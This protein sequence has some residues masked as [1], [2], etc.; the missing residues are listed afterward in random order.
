M[1]NLILALLLAAPSFA[2]AGPQA[3]ARSVTIYRDTYGVPHV[4][5]KTDA[6]AVFGLMYAQAEDNFWQLETDYIGLIG[7]RAEVDGLAG[8]P[9]DLLVRAWEVEKGAKAHYEHASPQLKTVCDAFAAGLNYYLA[10]HPEVHPRLLTRFE[11]W[12]ALAEEHH[13]PAGTGITPAERAAAFPELAGTPPTAQ[14]PVNP[15]EGSNMWAV[16]PSR[17]AD[18][19]AL[20]LINPHVQFFGGGQR[21]EAHLHSDQGL[22]VSGFAMLGAPYIWSGHNR[23]LGWSHTNNY[24][25]FSDVYLESS[26]VPGDPLV[27]RYG[28]GHRFAVEWTDTVRV[29]TDT[30]FETRTVKFR[31]THHGPVLGVRKGQMLAVR[32]AAVDGG[33]MEESWIVDK[34]RNLREFQEALARR[35]YTGSNTIYADVKGNIYYL[36][37]N[38]VPKRSTK[39]DWSKPVDGS[40]PETEWQGLHTIDELPHVLNP[41]SGWVQNCNSTPF[42]TSGAADSPKASDYPAYMA[43]EADTPRSQRS[44][45][46]LDGTGRFT[47]EEWTKLGLD[48]K[49]GIAAARIAELKAALKDVAPE[50]SSKL[51]DL[52]AAL[53]QWDQVGRNDSVAATLFVRTEEARRAGV[54][55]VA[56]LEKVKAD[57]E[58]AWG[59]WRV[60][61]GDVNRLER[62][63]TSGRQEPFSDEKPS[64][65]VPG[66]PTF[67]GTIFTFGTRSA[68]GQKRQYGTVGNTYIAV[69][70]F[71][72]KPV[73]RS[74]LVF[75]QS[76][77]PKSPHFFDQAKL[78]STQQFKPAWF[79]LAEIKK[80][81]ERKYRP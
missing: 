40:D 9:S 35:A 36:H 15:N 60:P 3:L 63:H 66:A 65:P 58:G 47:F 80:H 81:T 21:Y 20:L 22:D 75:G 8:L 55:P 19:H 57:L 41:K 34:S 4:Y 45:A 12:F 48:T 79:T 44:R 14:P 24:A 43:P 73:A 37:G 77:D 64:L 30:G 56:A 17:S 11:P 70:D 32:A 67:T 76:A 29:K 23:Y 74:L 78:Y 13:G 33:R 62:I 49:V 59:T 6:G 28:A 52:L 71:G 18:G 2:A 53:E 1:R 68:P 16:A 5:A 51:A 27:Y 31:K 38:A 42:L 54:G 39:F 25:Q 72:K 50:R 10:K 26:D 7:R 69:V 61:W 46:I